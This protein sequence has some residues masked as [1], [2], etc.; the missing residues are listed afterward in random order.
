MNAF[1][2]IALALA[3]TFPTKPLT[4][5]APAH[6]G[7]GWDSTARLMQQV[8]TSEQIVTVPIEVV[9]RPGAGGT[10]GLAEFVTTRRNDAHTILVLGRVMVGAILSN[11]SAVSLSDTVPIARLVDE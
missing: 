1:S 10:I 7:G 5:M 3:I 4:I 11:R 2:I 8:L 6:P 9:N